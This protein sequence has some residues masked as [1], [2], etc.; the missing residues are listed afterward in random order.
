VLPERGAA[1]P[2]AGDSTGRLKCR[3][4]VSRSMAPWAAVSQGKD[5]ASQGLAA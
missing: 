3:N 2:K 4:V 5:C 1:G